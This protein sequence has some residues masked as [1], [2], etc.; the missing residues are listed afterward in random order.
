[1]VSASPLLTPSGCLTRCRAG[2]GTAALMRSCCCGWTD[3][4]TDRGCT[5]PCG[6]PPAPRDLCTPGL[7]GSSSPGPLSGC[8]SA[9]TG[10]RTGPAVS[11]A[12]SAAG[13]GSSDPA[14]AT[15][16]C[17]HPQQHRCRDTWMHLPEGRRRTAWLRV[18]PCPRP[19]PALLCVGSKQRVLAQLAPARSCSREQSPGSV[20]GT[21]TPQGGCST[22][23]A[24]LCLAKTKPVPR[25]KPRAASNRPGAPEITVPSDLPPGFW[26]F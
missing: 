17:L 4:W 9:G 22:G 2:G 12:G 3:S 18:S 21:Y 8:H 1:M 14:P 10:L 23:A 24:S 26:S 7:A 20:Q 16:V 19:V 13:A 6:A 11:T 25:Q 5:G 15:S